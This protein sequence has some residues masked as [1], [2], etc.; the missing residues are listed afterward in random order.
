MAIVF[1]RKD[2]KKI[3]IRERKILK[4]LRNFAKK[5]VKKFKDFNQKIKV[6]EKKMNG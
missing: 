6:Y 3:L 2:L 4:P 1:M 5:K